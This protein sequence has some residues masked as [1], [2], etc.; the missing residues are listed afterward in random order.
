M[1]IPHAGLESDEAVFGLA[2][3]GG[4]PREFSISVFRHQF[5][6]MIF[7]Y[8]GS[9]K[10]L[11]YWP[12]LHLFGPNVWSIR[13]PMALAGAAT[14]ALTFD[15][16]RHI[17]SR[18]VAAIA[19]LMLATDPCFLITNT[20]DW[21]P[22]AMEHLL[23]M[24]SLALFARRRPQ[25]A[26]F[27]LGLG[28]WNKAVFIWALTGVAAGGLLAYLPGVRRSLPDTR[29]V[30]RCALA[31]VLGCMPLAL[32]NIR[33]PAS[34]LR[35]NVHLS[36][37][38]FQAKV[39]TLR[40]L[41]DGSDLFGVVTRMDGVADH[42]GP[43]F[44]GLFLPAVLASIAVC[45]WKMRS[46]EFKPALFASAFCTGSLLLISITKYTGAAHHMVLLYP[47]PQLL[48]AVAVR[49]V[50]RKYLPALAASI[51]V[52]AN[53]LVVHTYLNQLQRTG[54]AGLFTDA[55]STLSMAVRDGADHVYTIDYGLY[56]N[57]WLLHSGRLQVQPL[58]TL[59]QPVTE[60]EQTLHDPRA[61]FVDHV[62]GR[63][64]YPGAGKRLDE[65]ASRLGLRRT[66]LQTIHDSRGRSELQIFRYRP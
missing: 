16:V 15:F 40:Y 34:T 30:L 26:C 64:Y 62:P 17:S 29:A 38:G 43:Q 48:V 65:I 56:E 31:F 22:V 7:Y 66:A 32:Y 50:R 37:E 44:H 59:G 2:T 27:V 35:S 4:L 36:F 10:G 55:I 53:L 23:L 52:S 19:A 9:L 41:L 42:S 12:V 24:S 21:G 46:G 58:W 8:A 18:T 51:L 61:L 1:L 25:L 6:L 11:L 63:E 45:V 14:V 57:L 5:P 49:S 3:F 54:G 39:A 13:L 20:F 60:T 33:R 47:M 28:L